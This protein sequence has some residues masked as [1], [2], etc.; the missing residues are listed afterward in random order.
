MGGIGGGFD[1]AAF[2]AAMAELQATYGT[3]TGLT[4]STTAYGTAGGAVAAAAETPTT[5]AEDERKRKIAESDAA[6][7]AAQAKSG[8][9]QRTT[10]EAEA[11][12]ARLAAEEAARK[13]ALPYG[14]NTNFF[15]RYTSG[16]DES[17]APVYSNF[18]TDA[19]GNQFVW[20]GNRL[21]PI[22][23]S[24]YVYKEATPYTQPD[25]WGN[26]T[27]AYTQAGY[28]D[29]RGSY[30][31]DTGQYGEAYAGDF[32]TP[33]AWQY[34]MGDQFFN[35]TQFF[36][37]AGNRMPG[38]TGWAQSNYDTTV[39]ALK[40]AGLP[41][42]YDA[43]FNASLQFARDFYNQY[44]QGIAESPDQSPELI[45]SAILQRYLANTG[46]AST[47]GG[48]AITNWVTS[49]EY[50]AAATANYQ[51]PI[52]DLVRAHAKINDTSKGF[53]GDVLIPGL[54]VWTPG[55]TAGLGGM[56]SGGLSGFTSALA[57]PALN[58]GVLSSLGLKALG[59]VNP[60][61]GQIAGL[62][63][64]GAGMLGGLGN[65]GSAIGSAFS[66][67]DVAGAVAD[68]GT[69]GLDAVADADALR[70]MMGEF[71]LP[72]AGDAESIASIISEQTGIPLWEVMDNLPALVSDAAAVGAMNAD[73]FGNADM[74]YGA[75]GTRAP[76]G[77]PAS[78]ASGSLGSLMNNAAKVA[79]IAK[80]VAA[81]AGGGD[82]QPAP[83]RRRG[84]SQEEYASDAGQWA[85]KYLD[86]DVGAMEKAGLV[87]GSP[88]YTQY[89]LDQA[90]S[91][92]EQIFS[93]NPEALLQG[94]SVEDL[95]D[96]LEGLTR[97]EMQQLQRALNVR[98]QLG[99]LMGSGDYV[100]PFTGMTE[101]VRGERI[102][103]GVAAYQRGLARSTEELAGKRGAEARQFLGGML[104]RN[105]DLYGLQAGQDAEMLRARLLADENISEE[106]RRR[107]LEALAAGDRIGAFSGLGESDTGSLFA[108]IDSGERAQA[109]LL[110][111]IFGE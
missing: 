52:T 10:A 14:G 75:E 68:L 19:A 63:N 73:E 20:M 87:A 109:A 45:T 98:G 77:L 102:A 62:A 48:Q 35:P 13:A 105:V 7:K 65:I 36:G 50:N 23:Q 38:A 44:G 34:K 11:E 61:L 29:P 108:G 101:A 4:D 8:W 3:G 78:Q 97:R 93:R 51:G 89:I 95:Q 104:G 83:Q 82:E 74:G 103:P 86:L 66:P 42:D 96:A 26:T 9:T 31:Y 111:A 28:Y 91:I 107:R 80:A 58:T 88:A 18:V 69:G 46:Q 16:T 59:L 67:T 106:E 81:L 71:R 47:P 79:Q 24:G 12:K 70:K 32:G 94:E 99:Q 90:N 39:A 41:V 33:A 40:Q 2:D 43:L 57:S 53:L 54:S 21:V 15:Q 1:P 72:S 30:D 17:G 64:M 84:Q 60:Q 37:W 76:A 6:A 49:P 55:I 100:D 27:T 22:E 92:I 110:E 56:F 25:E 5:T 85:A